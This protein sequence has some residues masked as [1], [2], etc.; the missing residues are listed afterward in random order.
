MH[1]N[2]LSSVDEKIT[3]FREFL[4]KRNPS[5]AFAIKYTTYLN[6]SLVRSLTKK[7]AG[8]D[9]IFDVT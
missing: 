9:C 4:M 6:S 5:E 7:E 1:T 2:I 8:V 3:G